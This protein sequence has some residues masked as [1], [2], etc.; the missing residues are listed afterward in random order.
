MNWSPCLL[1]LAGPALTMVTLPWHGWGWS[2][3]NPLRI[4]KQPGLRQAVPGTSV[5]PRVLAPE[6]SC[7]NVPSTRAGRCSGGLAAGRASLPSQQVLGCGRNLFWA[8]C[9]GGRAAGLAQPVPLVPSSALPVAFPCHPRFLRL[10]WW[11]TPWGSLGGW[12]SP[13]PLASEGA[14]LC[15]GSVR[16]E[17]AGSASS[18]PAAS[19]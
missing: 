15:T 1:L 7:S 12:A 18:P 10:G 3:Q 4:W 5:P 19:A 11:Q 13:A 8:G 2:E 17:Q 6:G 16:D 14:A 9:G